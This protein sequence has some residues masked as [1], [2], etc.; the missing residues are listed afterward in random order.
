MF[1]STLMEY[2]ILT[3]TCILMLIVI[4]VFCN[5]GQGGSRFEETLLPCSYCGRKYN[6]AVLVGGT[7]FSYVYTDVKIHEIFCHGNS[8]DFCTVENTSLV[9]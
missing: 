4:F 5:L 7:E 1:C 2:V 8:G 6:I 9:L 3:C